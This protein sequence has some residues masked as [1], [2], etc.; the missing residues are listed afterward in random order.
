VQILQP[1]LDPSVGGLPPPIDAGSKL[2]GQAAGQASKNRFVKS[3]MKASGQ[4]P[5]KSRVDG[6][7]KPIGLERKV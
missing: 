3:A 7:R 1:T 5:G 6:R 2:R 4:I